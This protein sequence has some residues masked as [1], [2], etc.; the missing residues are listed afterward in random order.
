MMVKIDEFP[1]GKLLDWA[2][3]K[4]IIT[5][6]YIYGKYRVCARVRVCV[7]VCVLL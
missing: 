3:P 1:R 6:K 7:F 4:T 2:V 5:W